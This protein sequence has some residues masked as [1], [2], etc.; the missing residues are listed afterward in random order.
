MP[1]ELLTRERA[2]ALVA[3]PK[4]IVDPK[5]YRWVGQVLPSDDSAKRF[6]DSVRA[7]LSISFRLVSIDTRDT[8]R[9][10]GWSNADFGYNLVYGQTGDSIRR[11]D[12]GLV[13]G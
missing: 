6:R 12:S 3:L 2:D 7:P 11:I 10:A 9:I 13:H 4:R 1:S 8:F 5:E